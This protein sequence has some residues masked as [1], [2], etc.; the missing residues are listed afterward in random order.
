M[1]KI[2]LTLLASFMLINLV[3]SQVTY[4]DFEGGSGLTW[5]GINGTYDS[6]VANPDPNDI[7]MSANV[8]SFTK[9]GTQEWCFAVT[10]MDSAMDLSTNN[11][12]SINVYSPVATQFLFKLEGTGG[13]F[14]AW[15]NIANVNVWQE[16]TFDFSGAA[17]NTGL[18]K[19]VVF[20]NPGMTDDGGTYLFDNIKAS[21]AGACA[22]TVVDP[23]IIDDFEC[24]RNATYGAG[25]NE[26]VAIAN[27]DASGI[28]TSTMVG[29][30]TD[31]L[32]EW[33]ALVADYNSAIDLSVK[34]NIKAKVWSPK[35]G[36]ILF[37][38]EGGAS[39]P[40][41]KW[42]DITEMNTW[43]EYTADFSDQAN[44]DH[45]KIVIFF[46]A[47]VTA[48]SGDV[49]LIDD[50]SVAEAPPAPAIEDFENGPS[51]GWMPLNGDMTN[52][53]TFNGVMVNP[54]MAGINGS[55]NVGSYS[56]GDAAFS[57]L[58]AF[59]PSGI[60]LSASPQLNMQVRAPAGSEK[61]IM[62]LVS[63]TQ[64]AKDVERD[65]TATM[66]WVSV[67]FNFEEF[68][69]ITDFESVNLIFDGGNANPGVTYMFDNLKQSESTVDP[70]ENV[71][72]VPNILDDFE[73]QRNV[74]YGCGVEMLS[75]I[76]N[77][78]VTPENGSTLVGE[79]QD[80]TDEWSAL[81]F[82]NGGSFDLSVRNQFKIK[83]WSPIIAPLLFKLEG[84]SSPAA[85]V[86]MDVTEASKW[87]EYVVDFSGQA[88]EDHVR[89]ALFFNGGQLPAQADVYYIDDAKWVR[90]SYSGCIDDH[91][92]NLSTISNFS[93]F[94]NGHLEA[95]GFQ[96]E[97]V[98]NPT[99]DA[100]NPSANVGE[101][102]KASDSDPWAG[103]FADLEA[104]IDFGANKTATVHVLMDH[105]GNFAIKL[106]GSLTGAL[107]L[108]LF[109]E[110]TKVG[111]WEEL[112]YDFSASADDAQYSR[113]TL[114]FDLS[115]DATGE[116]VTSYFDNIVMGDDNCI[117][118]G[119]FTP[120]TL[121]QIRVSPNPSIGFLQ[122]ENVEN[123]ATIEV[124]DL[125]GQRVHLEKLTGANIHKMDLS[126]LSNGM[127]ILT[128]Y[129]LKGNII[130]NAKIIKE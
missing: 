121:E 75:R 1:K 91:E 28:N 111:E 100:V 105:I 23:D 109:V 36:Q 83:V 82:E 4:E 84:G 25:W 56:K 62:Q 125:R 108:E 9:D 55:P 67:E 17:A 127:Y 34:N 52:H 93:Y 24:Q 31:P 7:N 10:E 66:E 16:Y 46:N 80:P 104:P 116:D 72:A 114:F 12:F 26:L 33:S 120:F 77:P 11:Q 107:P 64:G 92:S 118:T 113:I 57:T 119:I 51:L 2:I 68:D 60:D 41:E 117:T 88:A 22:G 40:S 70:C 97:V 122:I 94:A 124:L 95:E 59:L 15:Q 5:A 18:E 27:P 3:S 20:F 69:G 101:F 53:G 13:G 71:V 90:G 74:T 44:A 39:A 130:A 123:I 8:G 73:C 54:D 81:C 30:Y 49:Y 112:T 21:P 38:L 98:D 47:G 87:V 110:N 50:I 128:A 103:F 96:F 65:I 45:K 89:V 35:T 6:I 102:V 42:V 106:E 29:Q 63:A 85:E 99:P 48:D 126:N 32:D 37:K 61:V 43:V 86:W 78:Y 115:I 19:I 14:E 79:Y 76:D 129:N 58:T